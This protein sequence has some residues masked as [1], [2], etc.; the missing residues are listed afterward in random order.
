MILLYDIIVENHL[1]LLEKM[2]FQFVYIYNNLVLRNTI[3]Y[4]DTEWV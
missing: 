4:Y 1:K 3:L 2:I